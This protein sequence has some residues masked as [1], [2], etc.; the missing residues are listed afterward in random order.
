MNTNSLLKTSQLY[1]PH[2]ILSQILVPQWLFIKTLICVRH[3]KIWWK[4]H[5]SQFKILQ[6]FIF[7]PLL[8]HVYLSL[9]RLCLWR[10][11]VQVGK[12]NAIYWNALIWHDTLIIYAFNVEIIQTSI[13]WYLRFSWPIVV[14]WMLH[15]VIKITH[16][17]WIF[18]HL[19]YSMLFPIC[20][21]L[22]S[23]PYWIISQS[24]KSLNLVD[25]MINHKLSANVW[26][27]CFV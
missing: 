26:L 21:F 11:N 5:H 4:F 20:I 16:H 13:S 17:C 7:N 6:K 9:N 1:F 14:R 15:H 22:Q 19:H 23:F 2:S 25:F 24:N 12:S 3:V 10:I 18:H 8:P 27:N